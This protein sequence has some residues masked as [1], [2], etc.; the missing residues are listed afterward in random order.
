MS[1][2][3]CLSKIFPATVS[4]TYAYETRWYHSAKLKKSL[5]KTKIELFTCHQL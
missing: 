5:K 3:A 4:S 2:L 1:K